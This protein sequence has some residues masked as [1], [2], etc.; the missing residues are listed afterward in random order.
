MLDLKVVGSLSR[1]RNRDVGII[2]KPQSTVGI[3]IT[4]DYQLVL[5]A[6]ALPLFS[7]WS[8]RDWEWTFR[9]SRTAFACLCRVWMMIEQ[10]DVRIVL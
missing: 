5:R 4:H 6:V 8:G 1:S 3:K 10:V 7:G 2:V 9:S